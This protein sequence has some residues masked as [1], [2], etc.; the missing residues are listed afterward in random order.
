MKPRYHLL[1]S[2]KCYSWFGNPIS[3]GGT[4]WWFKDC[5]ASP[6][7]Q[8]SRNLSIFVSL[9]CWDT[10][11]VFGPPARVSGLLPESLNDSWVFVCMTRIYIHLQYKYLATL[12]KIIITL[13]PHFIVALNLRTSFYPLTILH[14]LSIHIDLLCNNLI[15]MLHAKIASCSCGISSHQI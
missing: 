5:L 7:P 11:Q 8:K 15:P 12:P 1:L 13:L 9:R 14:Q 4:R 10:T 6:E 3:K 2:L